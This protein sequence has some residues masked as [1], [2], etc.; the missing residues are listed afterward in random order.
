MGVNL[1]GLFEP[2]TVDSS[3]LSNQKLAVDAYNT[4]YQFL[5][6]IRQYDGTPLKDSNGNITSHL[7]GLF[8][9]SLKLM[10]EGI[11]LCFV[12][13]G[14]PSHLKLT[15]LESRKERKIQARKEY[16]TAM[17]EG[18]FERAKSKASQTAKIDD[19]I[20]SESK[21]LLEAMGMPLI[22]AP[23][24]GEAQSAYMVQ[25]GLCYATV[26]QDYDCLLFGSPILVRN[27]NITGKRKLPGKN[28]YVDV[29]TELIKLSNVLNSL[30][31]DR[32]QLILAG[33]LVGTDFNEGVKGVGPKTAVK[34]VKE[35]K[36]L[37]TLKQE[38]NWSERFLP[39]VFDLFK[40]PN[41]TEVKKLEW[42]EIDPDAV[43]KVLVDNHEFSE[44]RVN[45]A[46]N[47]FEETKNKRSQT[48][49][50]NF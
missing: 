27:L 34:K 4:I 40:R 7:S 20:I 15:T 14:K 5:S 46:L 37:Q 6:T 22:Q 21:K 33:M 19:K 28:V 24:E 3:S 38:L 32:D 9:R 1:K 11:R 48:N 45:S 10:S 26:S 2:E 50:L 41:V 16:E 42:S 35:L 39:D 44:E 12:F 30:G 36:T 25:K 49:L 47:N 43:K 18:D 13:D 17:E 23:S 31:I 29:K 8:Y